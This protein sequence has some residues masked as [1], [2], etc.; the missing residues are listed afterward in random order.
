MDW[1]VSVVSNPEVHK[2]VVSL[3]ATCVAQSTFERLAK[4]KLKKSIEWQFGNCLQKAM[5]DTAHHLGWPKSKQTFSK[6]FLSKIAVSELG[7]LSNKEAFHKIF[8]DAAGQEVAVAEIVHFEEFLLKQLA[9]NEH[10]ELWKYFGVKRLLKGGGPVA[11]SDPSDVLTSTV[12]RCFK[13][14]IVGRGEI[15]GRICEELQKNDNHG[16]QLT[17]V[18]GVGKTAVLQEVYAHFAKDAFR[19]KVFKHIALLHYNGSMDRSL[20]EQI[21]CLAGK[22][23]GDVWVYMRNLCEASSVLLLIDD[24]RENKQI[25]IQKENKDNSFEKLLT[26]NA[27]ILFASRQLIYK[28]YFSEQRVDVLSREGC[29]EIFQTR[30]WGTNSKEHPVLSPN[31]RACIVAIIE[32]RARRNTLAVQRLG[33][34]A[35][36]YGASLAL[37]IEALEQRGFVIRKDVDDDTLQEEFNKLYRFEDI[38]TEKE[39]DKK[40]SVLEAFALFPADVPLDQEMCV[41]WLCG[42]VQ[43]EKKHRNLM[44]IL[45]NDLS[46]STW[47]KKHFDKESETCAYSM[48]QIVKGAV[49]TQSTIVLNEHRN[50]LTHLTDYISW[51]QKETFKKAQPHISYAESLAEYFSEKYAA[52]LDLASLMLWLARYY[53]AIADYNKALVWYEKALAVR[54]RVLGFEHPD[55]ATTCNNI[56]LVYDSRGAYVEALVWYEKALA[57]RERVLGFEHPDTVTIYNNIAGVY[58]KQGAYVEAL[59]WYEKALAVR[60]RVLGFEHFD[61]VMIYNRVGGVCQAQGNYVD[62]L[63]WYERVRVFFEKALGER[64]LL[65]ATIYDNIAS[66]YRDQEDYLKALEWYLKSY[67]LFKGLGGLCQDVVRVRGNME[68]VYSFVGFDEAFEDWLA[69]K[70]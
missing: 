32:N 5:E 12:L 68:A 53:D 69:K 70:F 29:M 2:F 42:D 43:I 28:D 23:V 16:I 8:Q 22:K 19:G 38:E 30:R 36:K 1:L 35:N 26:L 39:A 65:I 27:T 3:A 11:D 51:S 10:A 66:V 47:L 17:G 62:A 40:K 37:L 54:E 31:D 55:T 20:T 34:I 6:D 13:P 21:S 49:R 14:S 57:V 4:N 52:D 46:A 15:V 50:L 67:G 48:H 45:L 64:H 58:Y 63:V 18:G 9:Q 44:L 25:H 24:N 61:T 59:V 60:E 56:G 33:S 7:N 41:A